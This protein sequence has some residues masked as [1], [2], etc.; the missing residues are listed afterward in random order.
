MHPGPSDH[1]GAET[2]PAHQDP[3]PTTTLGEPPATAPV[4]DTSASAVAAP[5]AE[6]PGPRAG[7]R[8]KKEKKPKGPLSFLRELPV[9]LLVAFLLALV[10]KTFLVQ[11]FYIPSASME[12][13]L[14]VGDRV[15]VNKLV[16]RF[17]PPRRGDIIVFEDPNPVEQ[18]HRN[19]VSAFVHWL[20]E[21][22]GV[23]N[24]P[25][26]DFIKRVIGLPGETIEIN[27]GKVF[28]DGKEIREPYL[29]PSRD[30]SSFGPETVPADQLFVMGDN[31]ANS[32]DSR[33]GLG[34]IPYDKVVGRAFVIIWPPSRVQWL[35]GL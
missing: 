28:I 6:R 35:H 7:R 34:T 24:N 16:Y 2:S 13:T 22:L 8:G 17:H 4:E 21:G 25:E 9:L 12:N 11:A 23:S 26:K 14:L 29:N 31:R 32:N 30:L 20:T 18:P 3:Q 33:R 10:I 19:P 27:E 1:D 5:P 15:L